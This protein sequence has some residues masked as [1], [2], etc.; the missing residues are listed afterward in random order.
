MLRVVELK[1]TVLDSHLQENA[2]KIRDLTERIIEELQ[3]HPEINKND[4]DDLEI[5]LEKTKT[6]LQKS[7]MVM[8]L[9]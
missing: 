3:L 7:Y 5:V 2:Y 8:K 9:Q 1:E 4:Y 6:N